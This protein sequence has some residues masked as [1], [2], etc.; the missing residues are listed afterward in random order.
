[1][2]KLWILFAVFLLVLPGCYSE[3]EY[4][5]QAEEKYNAAR[6]AAEDA[7]AN[8]I[9]NERAA[10]SEEIFRMEAE[11]AA[12]ETE[13]PEIA[14]TETTEQV[15]HMEYIANQNSKVF[16]LSSCGY[17]P[18]E[19]NRLYLETREE[20]IEEGFRPCLHCDP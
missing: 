1:M 4:D 2:K 8:R 10:L 5:H 19:K 7:I 18:K 3:A 14:E 16:H 20:A 15:E 12:E 13:E 11:E 17:L 9:S 6:Q